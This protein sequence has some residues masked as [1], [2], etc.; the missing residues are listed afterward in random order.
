M[1]SEPSSFATASRHRPS[2]R[3][4]HHRAGV[5]G[6]PKELDR[7]LQPSNRAR[8]PSSSSTKGSPRSWTTRARRGKSE[9]THLALF[10][11]IVSLATLTAAAGSRTP[12]AEKRWR[13][14]P[15]GHEVMAAATATSGDGG[16]CRTK[17]GHISKA[18]GSENSIHRPAAERRSGSRR[19]ELTAEVDAYEGRA[20]TA[21]PSRR[22]S[23]STTRR[24]GRILSGLDQ[25][26]HPIE[27]AGAEEARIRDPPPRGVLQT[28][29]P[30][31]ARARRRRRTRC[32]P[33]RGAL[34]ARPARRTQARRSKGAGRTRSVSVRDSRYP[35]YREIAGIYYFLGHALNDSG[36][37]PS[38]A[39][40]AI[41]RLRQPLV[42]G[43]D[44]SEGPREDTIMLCPRTPTR[45]D[46]D[47]NA[48]S[49]TPRSRRP[50]GTRRR[51][52]EVYPENWHV[53]RAGSAPS[54]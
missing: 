38:A 10:C 11:G 53:R 30:V 26:D 7:V 20:N 32:T 1:P 14:N 16:A 48:P 42:S 50:R 2:R 21:T 41:A 44:G 6:A 23:S 12:R 35:K 15:H 39:G 36:R 25:G 28:L 33:S 13:E 18:A 43:Q 19:F 47:R 49:P 34:R 9:E 17:L 52:E 37:V 46:W 5:G 31:R 51:S 24:S 54:G 29:F 27:K 3:R 45:R 22:S 4:R 8:S 40:V